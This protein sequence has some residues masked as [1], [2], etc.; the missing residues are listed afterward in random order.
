MSDQ[1]GFPKITDALGDA[2]RA[3]DLLKTKGFPAVPTLAILKDR[4]ISE[5]LKEIQPLWTDAEI[6]RRCVIFRSVGDPR[7]TLFV[8]GIAVLV[9]DE[10]QATQE[11]TDSNLTITF[12]QTFKRVRAVT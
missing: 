2:A 3:L 8:D 1:P 9:F 4:A 7:E 11:W 5:A 6:A 10:P 12:T